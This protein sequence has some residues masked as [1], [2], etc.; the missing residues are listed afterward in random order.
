MNR[1]AKFRLNWKRTM[2]SAGVDMMKFPAICLLL[3]FVASIW[4][5]WKTSRQ[6]PVAALRSV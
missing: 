6:D 3:V 2:S 4:P 1:I 5:A